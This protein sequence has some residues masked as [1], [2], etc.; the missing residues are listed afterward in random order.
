MIR[1]IDIIEELCLEAGLD[2]IHITIDSSTSE[3]SVDLSLDKRLSIMCN[4]KMSPKAYVD[5][6]VISNAT[7]PWGG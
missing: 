5:C 4:S 2:S 3:L 6:A 1:L 7:F